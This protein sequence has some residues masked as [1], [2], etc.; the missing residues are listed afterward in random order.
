MKKQVVVLLLSTII[1]LDL[2]AQVSKDSAFAIL[3]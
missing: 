3:K 1:G 2:F